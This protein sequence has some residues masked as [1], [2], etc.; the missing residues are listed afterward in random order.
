MTKYIAKENFLHF[1]VNRGVPEEYLKE[2]P[3][4]MKFVNVIDEK[5][6]EGKYGLKEKLIDILDDGK[7]NKSYKPKG[8][9][10]KK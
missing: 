1:Q 5:E 8:K 2:H 7:L 4:L 3:H 9:K 10:N 6:S